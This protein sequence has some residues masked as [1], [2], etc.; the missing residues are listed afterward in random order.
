M[1][2]K[3]CLKGFYVPTAFTPDNNGLND[4]F[5]PIIAGHVEEYQFNVYNRWGQLIF[6][7]RDVYKGWN[8]SIG[9]T[10]QGTHVFT[11]I[12]TYKLQGQAIKK[13]QGKVVV[14]K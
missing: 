5:R 1:I 13:E 7:T 11:W 3:D 4:F 10:V 9:G 2:P 8:G 6:S 14:I 12:C